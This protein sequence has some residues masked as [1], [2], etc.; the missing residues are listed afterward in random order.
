MFS[1]PQVSDAHRLRLAAA[2]AR[3]GAAPARSRHV[4]PARLGAPWDS[5]LS[6]SEENQIGRMIV[7]RLREA[8]QLLDDPELPSTSRR[9]APPLRAREGGQRFDFFVV[10][11]PTINAFALPG[12]YVG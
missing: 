5:V 4:G 12:G 6:Q 8:D 9:R 10:R 11:D 3:C 2:A 1:S 7:H